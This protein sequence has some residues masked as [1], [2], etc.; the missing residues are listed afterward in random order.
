MRNPNTICFQCGKPIYRRPTEISR[1][2]SGKVFCSQECYGNYCRK[3]NICKVCGK[4]YLGR[5]KVCSRKCSNSNRSGIKYKTGR[6]ADRAKH[7]SQIRLRLIED[8]GCCCQCCGCSNTNILESHHILE[9]SNGGT[10]SPDNLLLLCPNCHTTIHLGDSNLESL[11][12]EWY[13]VLK[14]SKA[15]N[16]Y[17]GSS[18]VLSSIIK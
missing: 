6:R 4:E 16:C 7:S 9:K 5:N 13:L 12:L 8:R 14:T 1:S 15:S 2:I 11:P 17:A 18:P 10:D 3:P